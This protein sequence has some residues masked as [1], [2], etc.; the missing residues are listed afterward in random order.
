[1]YCRKCGAEND[2]NAYRCVNCGDYLRGDGSGRISYPRTSSLAVA[3][4]VC[5]IA[6]VFFCFLIGQ[7]AGI[8][9]GNTARK[10]IR[11]SGGWITGEGIATA[12]IVIGWVGIAL[13]LAMLLLG[14]ILAVAKT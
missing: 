4:L 6:G 1:M 10:Q 13:D 7:I 9:L 2:D 3:S 8:I 12:G 5:S 11:R 14:V